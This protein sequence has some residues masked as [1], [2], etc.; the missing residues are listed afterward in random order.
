MC[1]FFSVSAG[2]AATKRNS[3]RNL[4][5]WHHNLGP[6]TRGGLSCSHGASPIASHTRVVIDN[7][8]L[9][10]DDAVEERCTASPRVSVSGN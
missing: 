9:L 2:S 4:T 1:V 3:K 5:A 10:A 7:R 6:A 8:H